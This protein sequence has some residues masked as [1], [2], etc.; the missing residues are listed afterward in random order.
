MS[1]S[2]HIQLPTRRSLISRLRNRQDDDS[3]RDFFQTY[4]K[5]I[6]SF[7]IRSGCTDA[8]AEEVVQETVISLANKMPEYRYEPATC[9]FKGWLLHLTNCR[10]IDQLRKR[11]R[12]TLEPLPTDPEESERIVALG[13]KD[14]NELEVLWDQEWEKNLMDA[15]MERVKRRINAE[16]YQIFHLLMVKREPAAKVADLLKVSKARLA[17][18]K[19]RVARLVRKEVEQL[20]QQPM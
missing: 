13:S 14:A 18:V 16:H 9:S 7:A 20:K 5:L 10:V 19:H 2:S 17:L 3:W 8:E 4:W 1:R 15:A 12:G 11:R 6:Y